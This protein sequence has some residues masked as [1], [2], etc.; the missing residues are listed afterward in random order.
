MAAALGRWPR[1]TADDL[2]LALDAARRAAPAG[3]RRSGRARRR[4]A[5][6]G[7]AAP[8]TRPDPDGLGARA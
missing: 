3:A 1:S 2:G 4:P 8:S 6:G 7:G 5:R